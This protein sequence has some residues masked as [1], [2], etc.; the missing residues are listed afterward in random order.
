MAYTR[1]AIGQVNE[2][3]LLA[4]ESENRNITDDDS[5]FSRATTASDNLRGLRVGKTGRPKVPIHI[6]TE[7]AL[8]FALE[9]SQLRDHSPSSSELVRIARLGL[10]SGRARGCHFRWGCGNGGLLIQ[11]ARHAP[12]SF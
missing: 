12:P 5:G 11:N 6:S 2:Q 3:H 8:C 7:V 9:L 4:L 10:G 1:A